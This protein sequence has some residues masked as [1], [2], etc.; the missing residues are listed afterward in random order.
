MKS[1]EGKYVLG[2]VTDEEAMYDLLAKFLHK[3]GYEVERVLHEIKED[4]GLA[5]IIHAPARISD[6]Q[7]KVLGSQKIKKLFIGQ[8]VDEDCL[9]SDDETI[10]LAQRPLN[11]KQLSDTIRM[12]L[13]APNCVGSSNE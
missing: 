8:P 4:E 1:G 6:L 2:I 3:E 12:M 9:N 7:S 10:V 11:L 5:L 13:A